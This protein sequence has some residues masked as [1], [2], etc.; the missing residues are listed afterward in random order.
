MFRISSKGGVF[1]IVRTSLIEEAASFET[2]K[3]P[4]QTVWPLFAAE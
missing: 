3:A 1:V 2:A 4:P